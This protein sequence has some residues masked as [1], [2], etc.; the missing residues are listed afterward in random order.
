MSAKYPPGPKGH[1]LLGNLLQLRKDRVQFMIECSRKYGDIVHFRLGPTSHLYLLNNPTYIH[2]VLVGSPEKFWKTPALKK[3]ST[4]A[5][6]QGLLTSEGDFHKKQRQL[7]QPAFHHARIASYGRV[8][9]DHTRRMLGEWQSGQRRDIY[10]DMMKVTLSIVSEALFGASVS[11]DAEKIGQAIAEGIRIFHE[12]LTAP[13]HT[14]SWIATSK[15][16]QLRKA[17]SFVEKTI[18]RIIDERRCSGMDNGDLLSMLLLAVGENGIGQMTDQQARDEVMTLFIAGYETTATTLS[19]VWYLLARYPEAESKLIAELNAVLNGREPTLDDLPNLPYTE[20]IVKETLRLYPVSWAIGRQAIEDVTFGDYILPKGS[21]VFVSPY[22]MQHDARF[23]EE[24]EAFIP[25]RFSDN[26]EKR[27]SR[28]VYFPF[29][30]GP[31]ICIGQAFA[32]MEARLVLATIAQRFRCS[33]ALNQTVMI[34]P[35]ITMRPCG[36]IPMTISNR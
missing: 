11:D 8:M 24:P 30:G 9:V 5:L 2:T 29:G 7:I 31:R 19:W 10:D 4:Q 14:P 25:E 15:N 32:M 13:F 21:L 20:M 26:Y 28:Y 34:D 22:L 3:N 36:G 35:V 17:N 6:G 23:F 18:R 12:R 33:L 16:K 27:L 1:F